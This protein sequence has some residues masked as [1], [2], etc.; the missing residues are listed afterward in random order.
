MGGDK[1]EAANRRCDEQRLDVGSWRM[2]WWIGSD[3]DSGGSCSYFKASD[4]LLRDTGSHGR[5]EF[6]HGIL[7]CRT[8]VAVTALLMPLVVVAV[9][10]HAA[11]G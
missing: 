6:P 1:Q 7:L 4:F 9:A 10:A 3:V 11:H 5:V 2:H 8:R